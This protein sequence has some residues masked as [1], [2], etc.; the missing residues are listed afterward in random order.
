MPRK[1]LPINGVLSSG[2]RVNKQFDRGR[3]RR[4]VRSHAGCKGTYVYSFENLI[5]NCNSCGAHNQ[6]GCAFEHIG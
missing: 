4:R 6:V 3:Y 1:I 5:T 2:A